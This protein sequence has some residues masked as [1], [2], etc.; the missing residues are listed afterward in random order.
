MTPALIYAYK[1]TGRTTRLGIGLLL[2]AQFAV[3]AIGATH[4]YWLEQADIWSTSAYLVALEDHP[5]GY[6]IFTAACA[7]VGFLVTAAVI[8]HSRTGQLAEV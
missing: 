1:A 3:I 7:L 2:G 8:R 5:W 4:G 6:G